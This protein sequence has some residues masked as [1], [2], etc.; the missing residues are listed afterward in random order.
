MKGDFHV[1]FFERLELKSS[2]LLDC[3]SPA[4]IAKQ[5]VVGEEHQQRQ[6]TFT[7]QHPANFS[8]LT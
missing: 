7:C 6:Q 1:R 2:C 8:S 4:N 3:S 5:R